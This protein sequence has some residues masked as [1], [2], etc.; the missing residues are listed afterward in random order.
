MSDLRPHMK[1]GL[2]GKKLEKLK[3]KLVLKALQCKYSQGYL[4]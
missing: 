3:L 4:Q 2:I 1:V